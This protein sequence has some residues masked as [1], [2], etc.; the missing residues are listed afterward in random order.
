MTERCVT[1]LDELSQLTAAIS[2]LQ[3]CGSDA[4]QRKLLPCVL[5]VLAAV[6]KLG[7]ASVSKLGLLQPQI[8]FILGIP[9]TVL[10]TGGK[11]MDQLIQLIEY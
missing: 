2:C 5:H 11:C 9:R 1:L 6:E 7:K 10:C 4:G 3:S 8:L